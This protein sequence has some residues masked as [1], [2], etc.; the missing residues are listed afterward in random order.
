M[1]YEEHKILFGQSKEYPVEGEDY[2]EI[3]L[4]LMRVRKELNIALEKSLK[5]KNAET[6]LLRYYGVTTH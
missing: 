6:E 1:N 3:Y 2:R 4:E 5:Y